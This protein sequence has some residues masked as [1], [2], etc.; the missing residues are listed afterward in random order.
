MNKRFIVVG[1]V[2]GLIV[3]AAVLI[4]SPM[5]GGFDAMR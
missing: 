3:V 5:F 4:G 1:V 2:L